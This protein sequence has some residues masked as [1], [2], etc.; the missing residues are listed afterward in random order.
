MKQKAHEACNFRCLIKTERLFKIIVS[1]VYTVQ[2][3][4]SRKWCKIGTLLLQTTNRK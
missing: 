3:V 1:H 4:I 2:V